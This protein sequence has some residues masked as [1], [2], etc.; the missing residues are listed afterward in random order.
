MKNDFN[1]KQINDEFKAFMNAKEVTPPRSLT[2]NIFQMVHKDLNPSIWELFSKLALIQMIVGSLSLLICSQ[3]GIG[4]GP[5]VHAFMV[6]GETA[7]MA[8]CGG[9]FLGVGAFAAM[10]FLSRPEIEL[11]RTTGYL[12]M[13]AMGILSL[14]IFFGFGA[15]IVVSLAFV[16]LLGGFVGAL[17]VVEASCR[18]RRLA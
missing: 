8:L 2:E 1:S 14:G 5:L 10:H 16:W 12:P 13:L 4:P 6:F 11:I 18:F 9:L 17:I 15:E 7:C 3:F